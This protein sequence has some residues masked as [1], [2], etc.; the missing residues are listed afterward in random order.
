MIDGRAPPGF[1]ALTFESSRPLAD[2]RKVV[3]KKA[4]GCGSVA[5]KLDLRSSGRGIE[6][7]SQQDQNKEIW[8]NSLKKT[9]VRATPVVKA[10]S[11]LGMFCLFVCLEI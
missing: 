7:C 8:D 1:E 3:T 2:S 4:R 9:F 10:S 11:D 5:C 6:T